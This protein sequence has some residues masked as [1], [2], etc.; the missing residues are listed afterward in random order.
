MLI[1]LK[2]GI[3]A[4]KQS[5]V[6]HTGTCQSA[7]SSW[8]LTGRAKELFKRSDSGAPELLAL[9]HVG[10]RE[11]STSFTLGA[12]LSLRPRPLRSAYCAT[13]RS[14]GR[15]E[16][17]QLQQEVDASSVVSEQQQGVPARRRAPAPGSPPRFLSLAAWLAPLVLCSDARHRLHHSRGRASNARRHGIDLEQQQPSAS[18]RPRWET[19]R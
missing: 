13:R 14:A 15:Q 10:E 9:V 11:Q 16:A 18:N 2:I 3:K 7:Q 5:A 4:S 1:T 17:A 8:N 6:G 12:A 19:R